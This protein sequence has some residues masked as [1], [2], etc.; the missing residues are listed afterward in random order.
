MNCPQSASALLTPSC[1]GP[2]DLGSLLKKAV[3]TREESARL[4]DRKYEFY[5][6]LCHQITCV[7]FFFVKS[8]RTLVTIKKEHVHIPVHTVPWHIVS[9]E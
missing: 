9:A 1:C 4:E 2:L 6:A 5:F 3:V 7:G 8:N